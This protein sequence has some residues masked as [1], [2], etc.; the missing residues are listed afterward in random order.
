[1]TYAENEAVNYYQQQM[2]AFQDDEGK[3]KERQVILISIFSDQR[4]L[5]KGE[6]IKLLNFTE[7]IERF[8]VKLDH[9]QLVLIGKDGTVKFRTQKPVPPSHI[10]DLI[11]SMPMRKMEIKNHQE[12][13][14]G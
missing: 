7:I 9:F 11:D 1:M 4:A 14:P 2:R 3:L 10:Y 13:F 12:P 8:R 6:E 5:L